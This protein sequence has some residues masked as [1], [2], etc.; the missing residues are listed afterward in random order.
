MD[1]L[2]NFASSSE[3]EPTEKKRQKREKKQQTS[4]EIAEE[5]NLDGVEYR[6]SKRTKTGTLNAKVNKKDLKTKFKSISGMK[7][8]VVSLQGKLNIYQSKIKSIEHEISL[9]LDLGGNELQLALLSK[10]S[11]KS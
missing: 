11:S 1:Y 3:Q 6:K 9:I 4:D 5:S 7:S 10:K 2:S 8:R